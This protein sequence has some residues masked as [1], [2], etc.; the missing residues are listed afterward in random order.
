MLIRTP[1]ATA[2][3]QFAAALA[4]AGKADL[5]RIRAGI[6][7]HL[8]FAARSDVDAIDQARHDTDQRRHRVGLHRVVQFDGLREC[9]A[10][11]GNA[12]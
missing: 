12:R 5:R 8:Q 10:Q 9:G 11:F 7:R 4:G 2:W 6:Q 1:A 3:R